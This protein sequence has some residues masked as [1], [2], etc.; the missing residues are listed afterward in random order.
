[1][2]RGVPL[3]LDVAADSERGSGPKHAG[4][5]RER[6]TSFALIEAPATALVPVSAGSA[7]SATELAQVL[8]PSQVRAF[9]DCSTRWW[10]KYGLGLPEPKNSS[11]ALGSAVHRALE[12]NFREKLATG[13]DLPTSAVRAVFRD[14][15]LEH[16][17]ETV[18]APEETPAATAAMGERL[19]AKYMEEVAPRIEPAAVECDVEGEIG[20]VRVRGRVDLVD[21]SGRIIDVKTSA[22]RPRA[23]A[24]DYA[25][26][27]ATYAQWYP[28]A[29]GEARLD[30]LVR[31]QFV[32]VVPLAYRIAEH[33]LRATRVLYPLVQD[34]MRSGLYWPNRH[35]MLCSRRQCAFWRACER[36]FGGTVKDG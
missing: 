29:S 18:F 24:S 1:M 3:L 13:E 11:L 35:S 26:Q 21:R 33:D 17:R 36:E 12:V 5:T 27:L 34:G 28:G 30:T 22:R 32:Q 4:L 23:V 6:K 20:G 25:F 19:L 2:S 7:A 10:F 8:S 16:I 9:V 14:E 31:T 15:W